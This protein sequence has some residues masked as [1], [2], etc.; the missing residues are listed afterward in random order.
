MNALRKPR[1]RVDLI[2]LQALCETNYWR[3]LKLMPAMAEQDDHRIALD[4][5][6]GSQQALHMRVLERC[7][8]TTTLLLSHERQHDWVTPPSMEVRLY[9][10]A[11][12]AEV[13]AAYNSRR[14]RGVYPY[15][16][17]QMLQPDEKYQLN[18]FL[19]EWLGYCQRHGQSAQSFTFVH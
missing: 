14:F 11:G 10:D 1:Y 13:V 9:H 17:E 15:P 8:Y 6:D 3:L 2:G 16:N 18:Q 19:G 7:R 5:G 4:A 12:M